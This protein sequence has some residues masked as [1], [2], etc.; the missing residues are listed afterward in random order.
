MYINIMI[1]LGGD[2]SD[3]ELGDIKEMLEIEVEGEVQLLDSIASQLNF[4]MSLLEKRPLFNLGARIIS[5]PELT[6][7]GPDKK[8]HKF[9]E[10]KFLLKECNPQSHK[11]V[12]DPLP[13]IKVYV[14]TLPDTKDIQ[15]FVEE[16]KRSEEKV[17]KGRVDAFKNNLKIPWVILFI[18]KIS[19]KEQSNINFVFVR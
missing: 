15:R 6:V 7:D 10:V 19:K 4:D 1:P 9:E 14:C 8:A 11:N 3:I 12:F 2:T 13:I 17:D 18:S 16:N 5:I